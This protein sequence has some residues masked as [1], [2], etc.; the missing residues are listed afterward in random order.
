MNSVNLTG[1]EKLYQISVLREELRRAADKPARYRF[2]AFRFAEPEYYV[3]I[4]YG[5]ERAAAHLGEDY[6]E[7]QILFDR[8]VEGTVTPCTLF[9]V[10]SDARNLQYYSLQKGKIM[11]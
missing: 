6:A 5:E 1:F 8:L 7:A 9:D 11:L 2:C 10:V 4:L 3:E